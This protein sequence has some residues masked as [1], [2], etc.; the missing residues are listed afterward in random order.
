[1]AEEGNP[2]SEQR[3]PQVGDVLVHARPGRLCDQPGPIPGTGW[4]E[5]AE[6]CDLVLT[7]ASL[8]AQFISGPPHSALERHGER[9]G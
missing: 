1:M 5:S 6:G 9:R 2:A 7:D 8:Y 4:I 3:S